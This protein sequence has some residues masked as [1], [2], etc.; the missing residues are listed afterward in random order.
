MTTTSWNHSSRLLAVAAVV[1]LLAAAV[2][3]ATAVSVAETDAPDSAAVGEEVSLTITLTELY[4]EPSLEQWE[5]SGATE[6]TNPTWTVVL[7]DQT[8]AKVGQESFGGQTFAGVSV[9][10]DDGVSEVEVQLTGSVPE[11]AEY[12]YDPHQTFEA[13][14]LEQV[15]PGGGANELTSVATEHFT[16]ESQSAR[17]ALDAA[18]SEIEAAGNPS[19]ATETFGLAVSAYESENFD[20]A[21]KLADEAKGQA[22][23]AQNTANRNRLILMGAG[24][25]LVL[26]IA[27]GGV[28]YWRSQQDSTDRLG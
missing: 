20:N 6:L 28:F 16:E 17:E 27:A 2:A 15:P 23:Q 8:G 7:Y 5:L 4:R 22:Q 14:T 1:A 11:V 21:Q 24:A 10:A 13:A 26:G 12:T 9:V 3:P 18:S 19:E 25:L